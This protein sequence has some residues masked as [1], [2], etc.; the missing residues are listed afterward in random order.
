MSLYIKSII[1]ITST[2]FIIATNFIKLIVTVI[3]VEHNIF[4]VT[5]KYLVAAF[6]LQISIPSM[7]ATMRVICVGY[8]TAFPNACNIICPLKVDLQG[9]SKDIF[10]NFVLF[11]ILFMKQLVSCLIHSGLFAAVEFANKLL[12]CIHQFLCRLQI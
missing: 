6:D 10:Y 5:L 11:C 3:T 1:F 9:G 4:T 2:F 8:I 7:M 12:Y